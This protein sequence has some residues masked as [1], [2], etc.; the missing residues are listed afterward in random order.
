MWKSIPFKSKNSTIQKTKH[1]KVLIVTINIK[2]QHIIYIKK[3]LRYDAIEEHKTNEWKGIPYCEIGQQHNKGVCI[4]HNVI[5]KSNVVPIKKKNINI[6][7]DEELD[8]LT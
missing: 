3:A 1:G 6:M 5:H 4:F 7:K 2:I 8:E